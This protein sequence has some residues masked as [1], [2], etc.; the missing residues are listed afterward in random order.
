MAKKQIRIIGGGNMGSAIVD[1][2]LRAG[3]DPRSIVVCDKNPQIIAKFKRKKVLATPNLHDFFYPKESIVL[4]VKPQNFNEVLKE[5]AQFVTDQL[6][7]SIAAGIKVKTMRQYL[8]QARLVRAMPNLPGT[9]GTG[10]TAYYVDKGRAPMAAQI[11]KTLG[12]VVEVKQEKLID[13]VT[14]LSGSGP[15]YLFLFLDSLINAGVKTGLKKEA[16][17]KLAFATLEGS[18]TFAKKKDLA[19]LIKKVASKGGTTEAALQVFKAKKFPK[20]IEQAV[21]AAYERSQKLGS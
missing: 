7:I 3:T 9:I 19:E 11:L 5:M 18:L 12:E 8:K 14:A 2:L 10:I 4:A 20:I 16:A 21:Q 15:A 1:G 17:E 6:V 13:N